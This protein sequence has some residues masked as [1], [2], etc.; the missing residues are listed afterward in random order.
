MDRVFDALSHSRRRLLLS[1]LRNVSEPTLHE[2]AAR[3]ASLE[4]DRP[5]EAVAG[6][7]VERVYLSLYHAHVPKLVDHGLV[8]FDETDGTIALDEGAA[9]ALDV[10][11]DA[12]RRLDVE[13]S[14]RP[15]DPIGR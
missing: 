12:R 9:P 1:A 6:E 10:L 4:R 7:T 3:I 8:R 15:D 14:A 13:R 2:L 5:Q 11:A